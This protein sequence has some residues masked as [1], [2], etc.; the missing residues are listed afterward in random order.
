MEHASEKS[1]AVGEMVGGQYERHER[2]Q[3]DASPT[4]DQ[5]AGSQVGHN[6]CGED[7]SDT[8]KSRRTDERGYRK[9]QNSADKDRGYEMA[10]RGR[11]AM[12]ANDPHF[13]VTV[14]RVLVG[15]SL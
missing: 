8:P 9:H 14:L 10:Q 3:T 1:K 4:A 6:I 11:R 5:H 13:P 12:L 7:R 15:K 2:K